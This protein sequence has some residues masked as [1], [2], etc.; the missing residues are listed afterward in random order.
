M[1]GSATRAA[2][3]S[4]SLIGS[5][6]CQPLPAITAP[7]DATTASCSS[8]FSPPDISGRNHVNFARRLNCL[9][10]EHH[11]S[12]AADTEVEPLAATLDPA[13]FGLLAGRWEQIS[14]VQQLPRQKFWE[15]CR[16]VSRLLDGRGVA[17]Q[18]GAANV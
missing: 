10:Y 14:N 6:F 11:V 3:G 4:S 2:V 5:S 15:L 16:V 9:I 17:G 12:A 13:L 1:P 7:R 8:I 18:G